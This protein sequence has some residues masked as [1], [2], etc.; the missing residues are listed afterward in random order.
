[1]FIYSPKLEYHIKPVEEVLTL[2]EN[3]SVSL[4]L[5]KFQFFRKSLDYLGHVLL[6][7]RIAIAKDSTPAISDAKFPQ[8]MMQLRYFLGACNV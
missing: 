8:S 6:L 1:M 7:G 3:T 5:R 4:K 2:L